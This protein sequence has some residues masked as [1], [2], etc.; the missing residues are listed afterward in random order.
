MAGGKSALKTMQERFEYGLNPHKCAAVCSYLCDPETAH[1]EFLLAKNKYKAITERGAENGAL[2]FQIIQAFRPGEMTVDEA[3][4]IGY[5]TAMRWTKGKHQFFVCTHNDKAHI[6]NHIYYNSTSEDS[7]HKFHNF[8]GSSFAIRR[9]SDQIC[10]EHDLS[11]I[12]NPKQ[13]SRSEFKHYGEWLGSDKALSFQEKLRITIDEALSRKPQNMDAFLSL[14]SDAGFEHK[15]GRG[16]VLSFRAEEQKRFTRLRA[17]TLGVGYGMDDILAVIDGKK[18]HQPRVV[19]TTPRKVNLIIDIQSK[20]RD[21]KSAAYAKWASVFNLKQMAA[22]LQYLQENSL[23][24]YD[25]LVTRTN[26]IAERFHITGDAIKGTEKAMKRNADLKA[27]IV[28]YARTK[29][30]FEEYKARKY[31]NKYLSEH[32]ADIAIHRAAKTTMKELLAGE[33][34]PKMDALKAEWQRLLSER[35]SGYSE[36]RTAQKEMREVIAV[37]ANIDQILGLNER[38]KNKADRPPLLDELVR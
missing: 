9:L 31:S 19:K 13:H 29:A 10:L 24:N 25:D 32:E 8:I 16:G 38:E 22:A 17:S 20:L 7:T 26:A 35:K 11:I 23:L 37:K 33:K 30:V 18:Y 27:A 15:W 36:Y 6:H 4:K 3:Q 12:V 14:L 1:A 28:D 34:L 2:I 21:G 5:E